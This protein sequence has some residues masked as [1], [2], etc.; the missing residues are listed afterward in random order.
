[1][2]KHIAGATISDAW[3]QLLDSVS[4][5]PDLHERLVFI[6]VADPTADEDP[7]VRGAI[8]RFL[9]PS[10]KHPDLQSVETVAAT[11]FFDPLYSNPGHIW[12]PVD[13][14]EQP[15]FT[16]SNEQV[17]NAANGLYE[18]YRYI[19]PALRRADQQNERGT[20]FGRMI[21]WPGHA[22]DDL[23]HLGPHNQLQ[24][25]ID[26]IRAQHHLSRLTF[27]AANL[28]IADDPGDFTVR[29]HRADDNRV[30]SFPCMTH[31]DIG[32]H[33]GLINLVAVYR[34]QQVITK[35]YGN[36]V[37]L[38]RLQAF[39]AQQTG[40]GIGELGVH[41]TMATLG[42]EPYGKAG[43][44]LLLNDAHQRLLVPIE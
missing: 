36:F 25:R 12:D 40:F 15:P 18:R 23:N 5:Q 33:D 35:A 4:A 17:Q 24:Q 21:G 41:A 22:A 13:S 10:E 9:T 44:R 38:A 14:G 16:D 19:Y 43:L 2:S 31:I 27:N 30:R 29:I 3:L 6:T 26:Q 32:V 28:A 11:I 34:L 39:I 1:M 37:G 20:Y 42:G 8:N 7:T